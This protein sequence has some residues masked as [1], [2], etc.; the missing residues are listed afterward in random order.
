MKYSKNM[1]YKNGK[2]AVIDQI[3]LWLVIFVSFVIMLF[4]VIDYYV[5]VKVKDR[6]DTIANYA[7]RMK[8][9][10]RDDENITLGINNL[11]INKFDDIKTDDILCSETNDEEYK[12]KFKIIA[13][14]VTTTFSDKTVYSYSSAFNE[15]NNLS[16]DCNVTLR[17]KE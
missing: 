3:M 14:V 10:G 8:A 17:V 2:K 15:V 7:V 9:L 5:V 16:I 11:M 13:D 4:L 1:I 6:C 12:V